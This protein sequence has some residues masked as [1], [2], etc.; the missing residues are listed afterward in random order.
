MYSVP[1]ATCQFSSLAKHLTFITF[2]LNY[3]NQLSVPKNSSDVKKS[4]LKHANA[5]F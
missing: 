4:I 5:S 2:C 3:P 1:S